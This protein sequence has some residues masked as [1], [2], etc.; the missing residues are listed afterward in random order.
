MFPSVG[1]VDPVELDTAP[2]GHQEHYICH[3]MENKHA[4]EMIAETVSAEEDPNPE[5]DALRTGDKVGCGV[6][7]VTD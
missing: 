3:R 6:V 1:V 4:N 5:G 7:T 2:Y